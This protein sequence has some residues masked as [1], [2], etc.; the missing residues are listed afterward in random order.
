MRYESIDRFLLS[1]MNN[2]I[3]LKC[4]LHQAFQSLNDTFASI[5]SVWSFILLGRKMQ[6]VSH[7]TFTQSNANHFVSVGFLVSLLLL[8]LLRNCIAFS[9]FVSIYLF[10]FSQLKG[11]VHLRFYNILYADRFKRQRYTNL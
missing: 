7:R 9:S 2:T 3:Y 4:L 8:L 6:F 1:T 10:I 11:Y 5:Y